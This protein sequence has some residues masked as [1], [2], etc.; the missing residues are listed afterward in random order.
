MVMTSNIEFSRGALDTLYMQTEKKQNSILLAIQKAAAS[1][2]T[3]MPYRR[4]QS[5]NGSG[6][7]VLSVDSEIRIVLKNMGDKIRIVSIL[8]V[9]QIKSFNKSV[10]TN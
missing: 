3:P 6:T 2:F 9:E 7:Y 10:Q 5:L 1:I 8:G 4:L